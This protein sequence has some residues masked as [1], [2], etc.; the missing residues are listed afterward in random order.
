MA[1]RRMTLKRAPERPE[2]DELLKRAKSIK[3]TDEDWIEQRA[4]FVY[5]N[6]TMESQ[7]TKEEALATVRESHLP[8][9][10]KGD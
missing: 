5:G 3:M 8:I 7:I 9:R 2:L 6:A 1:K 10:L 4:S